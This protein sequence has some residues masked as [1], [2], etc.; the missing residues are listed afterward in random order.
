MR[1][2]LRY[3]FLAMAT[4]WAVVIYVLS[5][6]PGVDVP[7]LFFGQ[8]KLLHA[9]VFGIFGFLVAGALLPGVLQTRRRHLLMV[10]GLVAAYGVLDEIHQH[11]VPGRTA[12]V[13]DVVADIA[14]GIAGVWLFNRALRDKR[15][16]GL[17]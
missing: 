5:S 1:H 9:L 11:F 3:L 16:R 2:P 8:D 12:D 6:Q 14:G 7:P 15:W 4:G 13:F 17:H 10:V